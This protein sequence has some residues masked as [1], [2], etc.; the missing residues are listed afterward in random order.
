MQ[1]KFH[2]IFV[3]L[4]RRSVFVQAL[5]FLLVAMGALVQPAAAS[6]A[7]LTGIP[8]YAAVL[9][10]PATGE[11]LYARNPDEERHPAS[12]TKVMTLFLT[13][14]ALEAGDIKLTDR[15]HFSAHARNQAPSK[16]G[17]GKKQTISVSQAIQ[18]LAT[19]S[20]NDVAVALAEHLAGSEKKFTKRMNERA[21]QLGMMN[22]NFENA[23]GLPN[24]RHHST[25]RD[26][27]ILSQAMLKQYPQFYSYFQQ[28]QFTWGGRVMPNHNKL[29]GRSPGVDGIKT[30][31]TAAA[32]FTL[33]ASAVRDGKRLI[34][35][36]LGAPTSA[37][38]DRNVEA[39]L[40]AGYGMIAD[41]RQ[42]RVLSVAAR[43]DAG[44]DL[45]PAILQQQ[46]Q[47][48][49]WRVL[50]EQGS[51]DSVTGAGVAQ[52]RAGIV[53]TAS[54]NGG[55]LSQSLSGARTIRVP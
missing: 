50:A 17:I 4:I 9:M 10:D 14:E 38:R 8:K 23:S 22:T 48:E 27:A 28:Q 47:F 44:D 30:G 33:A 6:N 13:F 55:K 43:V 16:L 36:V 52:E 21:R 39:L 25:A 7:S 51:E 1:H 12:I 15:V 45:P 20:A 19:K 24:P 31:Y 41:R 32:G 29:L 5:L 2:G 40:D 26:I 35:V 37:S 53:R 46:P 18:A 54:Q 34:A 11:I 42:G 3:Q 49:M